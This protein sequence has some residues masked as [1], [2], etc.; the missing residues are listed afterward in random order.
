V[1]YI[2]PVPAPPVRRGDGG[3][4]GKAS[5]LALFTAPLFQEGRCCILGVALVQASVGVGLIRCIGKQPCTAAFHPTQDAPS[6]P[7]KRYRTFA[8][9]YRETWPREHDPDP[10]GRAC[11]MRVSVSAPGIARSDDHPPR[12]EILIRFN[13]IGSGSV[14][15]AS[16]PQ[17]VHLSTACAGYRSTE[18]TTDL[19][20]VLLDTCHLKTERE[21]KN[22]GA[23]GQ[24]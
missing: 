22:A 13:P 15:R 9:G 3:S 16:N 2:R 6:P 10:Q 18:R 24:P 1:L 12:H 23:A 7:P 5:Q 19:I 17:F 21:E 11:A 8:Q 4:L 14:V 20:V